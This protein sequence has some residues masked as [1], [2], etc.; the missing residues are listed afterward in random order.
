MKLIDATYADFLSCDGCGAPLGVE[1]PGACDGTC[2]AAEQ[3]DSAPEDS[4]PTA[5]TYSAL[6]EKMTE[7][8]GTIALRYPDVF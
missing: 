1:T 2:Y 7:R 6:F 3:Y 4:N 5:V 8:R